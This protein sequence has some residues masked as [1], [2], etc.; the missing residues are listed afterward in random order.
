M[1][2]LRSPAVWVP[3]STLRLDSCVTLSRYLNFFV[4]LFPCLY[5]RKNFGTSL[6]GLLKENGWDK[7]HN[8][9]STKPGYNKC[10]MNGK[11]CLCFMLSLL[12]AVSVAIRWARS[13]QMSRHRVCSHGIP[14]LSCC[15]SLVTRDGSLIT[16]TRQIGVVLLRVTLYNI[17]T[18]L[19]GKPSRTSWNVSKK[20]G[21]C[22][23]TAQL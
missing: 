18:R 14:C 21:R 17:L 20:R 8:A 12:V 19:V 2:K 7:T 10:L 22:S 4:P 9:C 1:C 3:I 15:N 13:W 16:Q 23:S 6:W 11:C 5:K